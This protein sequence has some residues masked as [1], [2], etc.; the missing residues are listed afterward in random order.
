MCTLSV[1][2][3]HHRFGRQPEVLRG[4]TVSLDPAT[5]TAIMGPSG[6]GKSTLLNCMSGLYTPTVGQVLHRGTDISQLNRRQ[7]DRL[8]S[9]SWGF[10]FQD[11]N[12]IE[13]L[14]AAENVKLPALFAGRG[15]PDEIA[16]E[17]LGQVGLEGLEKRY[18]EEL[19]GGQR[20]RV[21]IARALATPREVVFADEPTGALDSE[22]RREVMATLGSLPQRGSTV[23][24]V[25]H[26][27]TVA[28]DA[29]R[30]IF[31][32][33]GQ[34]VGDDQGLSSRQISARLVDLESQ[35]GTP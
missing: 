10:I 5:I 22:A 12:L 15:M 33:D 6:S 30:V 13:A 3:L 18:P 8:R 2:D 7:L 1:H 34:I 27:P 17:A 35:S 32:Y 9:A 19:S 16:A 25:T 26:D 28:A 23:V 4:I 29:S 14:T 31:L 21:A 11:Y 24:L 20:Q